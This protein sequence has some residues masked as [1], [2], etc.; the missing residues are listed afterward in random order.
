LYRYNKE[1]IK[2]SYIKKKDYC[3]P[4]TKKLRKSERA[5]YITGKIKITRPYLGFIGL[6]LLTKSLSITTICSPSTNN[7][8]SS[9]T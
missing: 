5:N 3:I 7:F 8:F 4:I 6:G 2:E 9:R 1:G